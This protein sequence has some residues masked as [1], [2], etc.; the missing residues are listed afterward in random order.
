LVT[1]WNTGGCP[2]GRIIRRRTDERRRREKGEQV[3]LR[4]R[5]ARGIGYTL[6]LL[7]E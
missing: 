3:R 1:C 5:K 6:Y 7:R 4:Y 2:I